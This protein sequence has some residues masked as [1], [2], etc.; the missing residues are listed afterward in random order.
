CGPKL[1]D[2]ARR[3]L[4]LSADQAL[5]PATYVARAAASTGATPY[6]C[7]IA[8]LSAATGKRLPAVRVGAFSRFLTEIDNAQDA[9]GPVTIRV[10][11]SE[12]IPGF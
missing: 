1:E 8:G 2:A 5:H 3:V 6:R 12:D 4:V 7:V 10:R 9:T 11:E